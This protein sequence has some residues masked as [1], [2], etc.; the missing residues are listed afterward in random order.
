[1]DVQTI[2]IREST[3]SDGA[4]RT[5]LFQCSATNNMEAYVLGEGSEG[6]APGRTKLYKFNLTEVI[7]K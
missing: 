2:Y 7:E 1:M 5:T 4:T 6:Y 3:D